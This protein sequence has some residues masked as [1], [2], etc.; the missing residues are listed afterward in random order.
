MSIF[1]KLIH[2]PVVVDRP[3]WMDG[4]R[5]DSVQDRRHKDTEYGSP[6]Y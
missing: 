5:Q 1:Q 3:L 4:W 6:G 2:V